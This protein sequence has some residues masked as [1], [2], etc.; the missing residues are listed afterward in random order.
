M[1]T[2]FDNKMKQQPND[3][4]NKNKILLTEGQLRFQKFIQQIQDNELKARDLVELFTEFPQDT[5]QFVSYLLEY[6]VIHR[7]VKAILVIFLIFTLLTGASDILPKIISHING[8]KAFTSLYLEE[9]G[10]NRV[11]DSIADELP[12]IIQAWLNNPNL[13]EKQNFEYVD[14]L[15]VRVSAL[16]SLGYFQPLAD[17]KL[18]F[19]DGA[20]KAIV[21]IA[22]SFRA[23]N[24]NYAFPKKTTILDLFKLLQFIEKHGGIVNYE[25]KSN[26]K[27]ESS[28]NLPFGSTEHTRVSNLLS[29]IFKNNIVSVLSNN[30]YI[31]KFYPNK[32]SGSID[33]VVLDISLGSGEH[34]SICKDNSG[35]IVV[36]PLT[37]QQSKM[38]CLNRVN[39]QGAIV[40]KFGKDSYE[41][42]ELQQ[43]IS[44]IVDKPPKEH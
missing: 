42:G 9:A 27:P 33:L 32:K 4:E 38:I 22:D 1:I 21:S 34:Y 24:P 17:I 43:I 20:S 25:L 35:T 28:A 30:L 41:F 6:P 7:P 19:E 2:F 3:S 44:Q 18:T 13:V 23:S 10:N 16:D 12:D 26:F 5:I 29:G 8:D 31:E 14:G 40:K 36:G 39:L 11:G 15:I 37:N